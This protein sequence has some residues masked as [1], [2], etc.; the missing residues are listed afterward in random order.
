MKQ[1]FVKHPT[2]TYDEEI[3]RFYLAHKEQ[4]LLVAERDISAAGSWNAP[5]SRR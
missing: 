3:R 4:D 2:L 1:Y 5:F